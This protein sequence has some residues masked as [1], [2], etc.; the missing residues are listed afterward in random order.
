MTIFL[1][2][3]AVIGILLL[4]TLY[5]YRTAFFSHPKHHTGIEDPLTGKT[6]GPVAEHIYRI[7]HIMAEYP[8]ETVTIESDDG[9]KLSGRYYHL[10][11]GA[12]IEILFHGYRSHAFRDCAGGHAM[13]RKMGYNALVVDQRAHGDSEGRNITFGVKERLDCLRWAQYAAER[14]PDSPIILCG[15]SMGAATVL[16]ATGLNLPRNVV[17]VVADSPYST[18][19]AII[20]KVCKDMHYPVALCR[21]FI[22]LAARL[23]GGF[24]LNSCTAKEAVSH[25]DIPILLLHGENDQMVPCPMSREIADCCT[26]S[27]ELHTFPGAGH[28]LCYISDP[29]RYEQITCRFLLSIPR[30]QGTISEEFLSSLGL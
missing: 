29:R 19:S 28:V 17:C 8:C 4:I 1:C 20:E 24:R 9:L 12:P 2:I 22:R 23:F 11:D 3:S 7:S 10:R 30:L 16:M 26:G 27:V 13:S 5:V 18:P 21:P 14:F 15:A 25:T 6:Y